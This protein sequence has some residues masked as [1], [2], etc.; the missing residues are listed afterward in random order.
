VDIGIFVVWNS[1]LFVK[2]RQCVILSERGR[3]RA[4]RIAAITG[5]VRH[6]AIPA[7]NIGFARRL[8]R[9]FS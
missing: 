7:P 1:V 6:G 5:S 2:Q 3:S 4:F 8:L 9:R